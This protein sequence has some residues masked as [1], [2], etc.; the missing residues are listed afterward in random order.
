[1]QSN[2]ALTQVLLVLIRAFEQHIMIEFFHSTNFQAI[3]TLVQVLI[4]IVIVRQGL[5]GA[6]GDRP[7][8]RLVDTPRELTFDRG[9]SSG[10]GIQ[11][12]LADQF[13]LATF[14]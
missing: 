4:A 11:L 7:R 9:R 10:V 6:I 13:L 3:L 5:I 2:E 1:M 14:V 8:N 12:T